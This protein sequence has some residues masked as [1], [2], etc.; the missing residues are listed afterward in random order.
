MPSSTSKVHQLQV[1]G[2]NDEILGAWSVAGLTSFFGAFP[3]SLPNVSRKRTRIS[4]F[5]LNLV[6]TP[7]LVI[8]AHGVDSQRVLHQLPV[9]FVGNVPGF[10][11][12]VP[13]EPFLTQIVLRL[14]DA[15]YEHR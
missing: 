10:N 15:I 8:T 7:G 11:P 4:V 14:P 3:A 6:L 1:Y 9:E 5:T 13:Q 2:P 12:V